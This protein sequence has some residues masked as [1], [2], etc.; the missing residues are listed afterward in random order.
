MDEAAEFLNVPIRFVRRIIYE[1]RIAVVRL[2][3]HVRLALHDLEA[4]VQGGRE[5]EVLPFGVP[6]TNARVR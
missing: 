2:G 1:R 5:A 6:L 3:R 4:F